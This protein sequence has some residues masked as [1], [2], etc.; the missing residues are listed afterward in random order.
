MT[1]LQQQPWDEQDVSERHVPTVALVSGS[2]LCAGAVIATLGVTSGLSWVAFGGRWLVLIGVALAI[3][4]GIRKLVEHMEGVEPHEVCAACGR[5][6][7]VSQLHERYDGRL[8]CGA[9]GRPCRS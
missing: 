7:P 1:T 3:L 6:V 8:V 9:A 2:F 5:S 4:A